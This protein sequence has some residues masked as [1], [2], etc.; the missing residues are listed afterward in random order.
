M[1]CTEGSY[2][3]KRQYIDDIQVDSYV[4]VVTYRCQKVNG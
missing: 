2:C 4:M 1:Y 3:Q